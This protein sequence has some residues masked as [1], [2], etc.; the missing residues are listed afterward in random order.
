MKKELSS[1]NQFAK[2]A[3]L[4]LNQLDKAFSDENLKEVS[5]K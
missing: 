3:R 2:T 5:E 4:Y 1:G